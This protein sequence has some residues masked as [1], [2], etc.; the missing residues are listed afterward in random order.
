MGKHRLLRPERALVPWA[1]ALYAA[2]TGTAA[3]ADAAFCCLIVQGLSLAPGAAL[4]LAAGRLVNP[5]RLKGA[6]LEALG[7]WALGS[8]ILC[9]LPD[10]PPLPGRVSRLAGV[11]TALCALTAEILT[12]FD[13]PAAGPYQ[14]R[15]AAFVGAALPVSEKTPLLLP[16]GLGLAALA[17]L[18]P[19]LAAPPRKGVWDR[20]LFLCCPRA[21]LRSWLFPAAI[22][23]GLYW[24]RL[25]S[26]PA[27]L[28]GWG[29]FLALET[30]RRCLN[31]EAAP[32]ALA[33]ALAGASAGLIPGTAALPG[34]LCLLAAVL[35]T[36][37]LR[38][39]LTLGPAL[40][41]AC[42]P[43]L[44]HLPLLSPAQALLISRLC[45]GILGLLAIPEA[46]ALIRRARL[47][48]KKRNRGA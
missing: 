20:A 28:G 9:L 43:A 40:L 29:L 17:G 7:L 44:P 14:L 36:L 12:C 18:I 10:M 39:M 11:L 26:A 35:T 13:R 41:A 34:L 38:R 33:A 23:G 3:A 31:G 42:V 5:R 6:A 48:R 47:N 19:A 30:P 16:A 27:L 37:P 32:T 15:C 46:L 45:A 22:F 25:A 24:G 8:L 1:M 21:L 4:S 2:A